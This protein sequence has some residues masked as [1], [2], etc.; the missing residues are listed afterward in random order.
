MARNRIIGS[1]SHG[2]LVSE[3]VRGNVFE[4][5]EVDGADGYGVLFL[6]GER[7]PVGTCRENGPLAENRFERN[8]FSH[9]LQAVNILGDAVGNVFRG[10]RV[11]PSRGRCSD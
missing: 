3:D 2:I 8:E 5:N 1:S 6:G 11:R 7:S 4:E 10:K 9:T